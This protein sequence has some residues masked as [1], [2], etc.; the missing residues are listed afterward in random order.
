MEELKKPVLSVNQSAGK[1]FIFNKDIRVNDALSLTDDRWK[2]LTNLA[3]TLSN[4][5]LPI[6]LQYCDY[7]Q[8]HKR[9]GARK[10]RLVSDITARIVVQH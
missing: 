3:K 1:C 2:P 10:R 8:A 7:M 9:I 6:D 4:V 5:V